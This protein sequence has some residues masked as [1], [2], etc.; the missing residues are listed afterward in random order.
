MILSCNLNMH[1]YVYINNIDDNKAPTAKIVGDIVVK[2]P[3][4]DAV[5]NGSLSSDDYGIVSYEWSRSDD[6]PAIGVIHK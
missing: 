4:N 6:S 2:L 5:L 1:V 3:K